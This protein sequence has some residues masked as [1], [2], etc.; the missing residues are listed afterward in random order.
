[1]SGLT[2]EGPNPSS[3][4]KFSGANGDRGKN[5]SR[6]QLTM[7]RIGDHTRLIYILLKMLTIHEGATG[8]IAAGLSTVSA[9]G[10]NR[11]TR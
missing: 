1:M 11:V 5:S 9:I 3:E 10:R 6:V 2:R 7:S 8:P 4:D